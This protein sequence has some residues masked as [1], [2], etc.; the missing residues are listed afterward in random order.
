L[1]YF[2]GYTITGILFV[3]YTIIAVF[4]YLEWKKIWNKE[5]QT[6]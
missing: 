6:V 1:Y 4:G 5:N 2:K 3:I